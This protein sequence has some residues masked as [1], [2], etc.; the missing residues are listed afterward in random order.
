MNPYLLNCINNFDIVY[1]GL[2]LVSI[3]IT[4]IVFF[5]WGF[6]WGGKK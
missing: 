1:L 6:I 4:A 2:L 5:A 3:G